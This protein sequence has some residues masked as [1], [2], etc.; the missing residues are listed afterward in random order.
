[1][2][3]FDVPLSGDDLR[4]IADVI[5]KLNEFFINE[6]GEY[7]EPF[8][9]E[10]IGDVRIPI[11]RLDIPTKIVGHAVLDAGWIGF[12]PVND[13]ITFFMPKNDQ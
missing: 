10:Y 4:H 2:S 5:D 11:G 3:A 8:Q 6:A 7:K 9:S 1:V 13:G 12:K